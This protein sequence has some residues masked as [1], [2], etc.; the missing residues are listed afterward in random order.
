MVEIEKLSDDHME[1]FIKLRKN[2]IF[3]L[4]IVLS[5]F[6]RKSYLLQGPNCNKIFFLFLADVS[7][8][9]FLPVIC[10]N[11][12]FTSIIRDVLLKKGR[13]RLS[14]LKKIISYFHFRRNHNENLSFQSNAC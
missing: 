1:Y 14:I 11:Q 3:C 4:F 10:K 8:D 13:D 9:V 12:L 5:S 2:D 6:A 7:F